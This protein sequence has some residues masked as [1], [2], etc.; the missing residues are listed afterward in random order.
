MKN[1]PC[2]KEIS[3]ELMRSYR[4]ITQA[5]CGAINQKRH[6]DLV[7][8]LR[9]LCD[10]VSNARAMEQYGLSA[11]FDWEQV[12]YQAIRLS[13]LLNQACDQE[14]EDIRYRDEYYN[15]GEL[16]SKEDRERVTI[17]AYRALDE[18]EREKEMA[19]AAVE[20]YRAVH[21]AVEKEESKAA[22]RTSTAWSRKHCKGTE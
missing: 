3:Q 6:K 9:L 8:S 1:D 20:A 13:V 17:E 2:T 12:K 15:A 19:R 16:E 14:A 10:N 18:L 4:G 22:T 21:G 11:F 7:T 5:L